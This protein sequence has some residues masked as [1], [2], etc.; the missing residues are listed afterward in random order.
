MW[1]GTLVW[2]WVPP[3]RGGLFATLLERMYKPVLVDW[4]N[5]SILITNVSQAK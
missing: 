5:D 1:D 4:L 2:E 3:H